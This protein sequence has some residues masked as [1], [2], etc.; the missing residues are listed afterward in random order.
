MIDKYLNVTLTTD[1]QHIYKYSD[2]KKLEFNLK[3][4]LKITH[5]NNQQD[6]FNNH[7]LLE[8]TSNGEIFINSSLDL[9]TVLVLN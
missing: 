6:I 9:T 7:H 4:Y 5:D 8:Y 2:I 3:G 1:K